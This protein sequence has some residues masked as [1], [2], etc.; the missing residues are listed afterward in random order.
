MTINDKDAAR[1]APG[2]VHRRRGALVALVAAAGV[3]LSGGLAGCA[4]W[5]GTHDV[6]ISE[7][8]IALLLSRQFPMERTVLDVIDLTAS[9]PQ[10]R[11]LPQDNRVGTELDIAA[12][13]RLFGSHAEGHLGLDYALRFEPSDHTLRMTAV[14]VRQLTLTSGPNALHG[15]DQRLGG[16]VAEKLL[17]GMALYRM[18][19]AQADEMDR[20]DL[21]ASSIQVTPLGIRLTI[22][23]RER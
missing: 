1:A 3:T 17:E 7:S 6:Q 8:Q 14:R 9:N 12:Q 16:L 4:A 20:L 11:L 10:V 5:I 2:H 23:P 13:D 18:K 19:P 21:Q 22:A 15:V